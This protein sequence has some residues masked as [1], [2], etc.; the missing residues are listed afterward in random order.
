MAYT[1]LRA[2]VVE[3]DETVC[4][5]MLAMLKI[6]GIE[7][8]GFSSPVSALKFIRQNRVD[9]IFTDYN[10]PEM[11]GL[12]FVGEVRKLDKYMPIVMITS[13]AYDGYFLRE[14]L[15]RGVTHVLAKPVNYLEF[16]DMLHSSLGALSRR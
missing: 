2:V 1:S 12:G 15:K 4:Q 3:D 16:H 7:A 6:Q 13:W 10:M 11:N 14:A 9:M 5:L 8:E